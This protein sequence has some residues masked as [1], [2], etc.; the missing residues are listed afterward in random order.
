MFK[1]L[2]RLLSLAF[3]LGLSGMVALFVL[4][5]QISADLPDV[6]ALKEV[7]LETPMRIYS[8]D[9]EL[10]SQYGEQRR[11]PVAIHN[12]PQQLIDAFLA[13]EDARF[14]E[15]PGI[16]PVGI[17]RAAMVWFTTGEK[18]QGA[19][20][21]TQQV[22]RNFFLSREKTIVRK[23]KEIF[24]AL[25]IEKQ[26]SKDEILELYLNKIP[27][28]HRSHGVGAAAQVY[29]GKDLP[30]LT[31]AEMAMI[32]GLP[33]APSIL[34]PISHPRRAEERRAVV[35]GRMLETGKITRAQYDDAMAAPVKARYHG[36]EIT[37]SA[38][39]LA[40]MAHQFALNMFGEEA[41]IRGLNIYTTVHAD[42]Q[43]AANEA[44]INGLLSYDLRH[45]YR[46]PVATLWQGENAWG[47]EQIEQH[48]D[49]QP[50]YW[51]L[52]P[53]VVLKVNERN[54]TVFIKD[55]GETELSWDG[56]K[57]ARAYIADNRQGRA[58]KRASEI[59]NAGEQIWVRP[60]E[61]SWMLGQ[62]PDINGALVA[63]EPQT[64]AVT[65]LTGGFNFTL[66]KFNRVDQAER[67]MGSNIK[68]FIY[69]TALDQGFTLASLVNDAPINHWDAGSGSS[70]KPRNSPNVYD[71]PI[72]VREGLA[73]S[74]NVV[75]IRL[76]RDSGI[77]NAMQRLNDFGFDTDQIPATE[78]LALG[79][80]SATPLQMAAGYAAFANGGNRVSP[81]VVERIED[82][83]GLV[84]YQAAPE[85]QR[86]ISEENAFLISSALGSAIQGGTTAGRRWNG[87]GWR[88]GR[89][90]GRRDIGGK[91][92]TTND[93]RD[94]WF[95]GF[96]PNRVATAWVGFDDFGRP[97]GRTAYH[98][99]LGRDQMAGGEFGGKTA[100]PIWT[101]Y[102]KVAL[103]HF[104][105]QKR[106]V[107]A[108]MVS[109]TIDT[110]T[111]LL[112]NKGSTEYFVKGT[113][114]QRYSR[115]GSH[116]QFGGTSVTDE[117]F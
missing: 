2:I 25:H 12:M 111:G 16:D 66:N 110:S 60:Q 85:Q 79:S 71:G 5:Q 42:E 86:I 77:A 30:E 92:G 59:L 19:S 53:A 65:A 13:T 14:Y 27:L 11:T 87:T 15:H 113:E 80:P 109:A 29:Y 98:P 55:K 17:V 116:Q 103:S 108:G 8:Q 4:Y 18:R 93:S 22:A 62:L 105:E 67:Q 28:G 104:P 84:L 35:L 107:P 1:W 112:S 76:L 3:L 56:L 40:E 89:A 68:P 37:L 61:D 74:K 106:T 9:N 64:G 94:A 41:Y 47:S 26:L 36:A 100:L 63:L 97:L 115:P 48:L 90:L 58:P 24:L 78:S 43:Q 52:E 54:A 21:I 88:A 50:R 117:L 102:M 23:V 49:E 34:N 114:P 38:P 75:S 51:P 70:W 44:L 82:A 20:T 57:W 96:N 33:K 99:N 81:F 6:S 7:R 72:R 73:R 91:T 83:N 45:G 46:G 31:L 10:I 39:Y 69:S 32:A 101:D 95:S